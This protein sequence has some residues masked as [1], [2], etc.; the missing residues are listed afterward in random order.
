M[1]VCEMVYLVFLMCVCIRIGENMRKIKWFYERGNRFKILV[2]LIY[3][4]KKYRKIKKIRN[5]NKK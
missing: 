3:K 4:K 2:E 1:G 5:K